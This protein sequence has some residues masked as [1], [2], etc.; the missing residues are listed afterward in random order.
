MLE[1]GFDVGGIVVEEENL[2]GVLDAYEAVD[3]LVEAWV[4]LSEAEVVRIEDVFEA[5]GEF[6][7]APNA[8]AAFD[9][10]DMNSVGV[11]E[12]VKLVLL[13]KG[14]KLPD[15][16]G[17]QVHEQGIP[18]TVNA[19]VRSRVA[20]VLSEGISKL[21]GSDCTR[22]NGLVGIVLLVAEFPHSK[23]GACAERGEG[24]SAEAGLDV[25][26]YFAKVQNNVPGIARPF[27]N[28]VGT[29]PPNGRQWV[30]ELGLEFC[31][32]VF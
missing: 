26:E 5:A 21:R 17:L 14:V 25:D 15:Q 11:A 10:V 12:N 32:K 8:H 3:G 31:P 24:F 13:A 2:R 9:F 30:G 28:L 19:G 1:G 18:G 20:E 23:A 22:F 16:P 4:R 29:K 27:G 7:I 6:S